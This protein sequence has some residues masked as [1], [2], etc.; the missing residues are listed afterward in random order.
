MSATKRL[1]TKKIDKESIRSGLWKGWILFIGL[2]VIA[3]SA[4][5]IYAL[6]GIQVEN[7]EQFSKEASQKHW[8]RIKE[9][10]ER[11]EILDIN[12]NVLA[13]TSYVYT[14]G[15]TPSDFISLAKDVDEATICSTVA[16][17]LG[18]DPKTLSDAM[19]QVEEPYI[20]LAKNVSK[21]QIDVLKAFL[22]EH[23]IGG[24]A[25]DSVAKRYYPN[26]PL[27]SQI[28]GYATATDGLLA[29]QLGIEAQ[30][31]STLTGKEGYS[32]VEID[33][34]TQ[35]ALP[36]SAPTTINAQNG[37]NVVL[38]IDLTIQDIVETACEDVF[39]MYD[40]I[41]GVTAIVMDPYT[42]RIHAMASYPDF[43]PNAPTAEPEWV[44][45]QVWDSMSEDQQ[46][47]LLISE[48]WRNRAISDT[49]EPGSTFKSLT[50]AIALEEGLTYE[51]EY[52]SDAPIDSGDYTISCWSQKEL[53]NH[54]TETL[55]DAFNNSC[56]PIFV[57]LAQRI[58]I[59]KFYQ[60]IH[61]FGFYMPTGIDLPVE[62]VGIFHKE[63][64][65]IDMQTLSF[66]ESSTV[67]PLQ[68][69][70]AYCAIVNGGTLMTPQIAT[71]LT[72]SNGNV[73]KEFEP[74]AIRTI[75]SEDTSSRI[76]ALMQTVVTE[77]TGREGYVE[78]FS[79]A[80][81]TSTSTI[82]TGENAGLHVLSF[83]SYAPSYDPEIVVLVVVNMPSDK[84]VGSSCATKT[85]ADII[86][87][88]LDY[89]GVERKYSETDYE[90][91][92][93][94]YELP[95]VSGMTYKEARMKLSLEFGK[96]IACKGSEE[97]TDDTIVSFSFPNAGENLHQ[98]STVVLYPSPDA[99]RAEVILPDFTGKNITECIREAQKCG[100]NIVYEGDLT[101]VVV[102]QNPSFIAISPT[103]FPSIT[104]VISPSVTPGVLP[105]GETT[106][107]ET[108]E[109]TL[110]ESSE[111][112][113]PSSDESSE[114]IETET[115]EQQTLTRVEKGMIIHLVMA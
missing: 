66:G 21:S 54:G 41:E 108:S 103:P 13:G 73:V 79:V 59:D 85:A 81:K 78:G 93:T 10:P 91:L 27:A 104:P 7:Y 115:T 65:L 9:E 82:E 111:T 67:T 3:A 24:T 36:F 70:N 84:E 22:R 51:D 2:C 19:K 71:R 34:Y 75:L 37:Y 74:K 92:S 33:N 14:V 15:I 20:Q 94:L 12:G 64:T 4:Y 72:D 38:S 113:D 101:G 109:T 31:N 35:G 26:G 87:K 90:Y 5:L 86:S 61:N 68:L 46:I 83:G 16:A 52:F 44:D 42:G 112:T 18:I 39:D 98:G 58:G 47:K 8:Q 40:V 56:N 60:Y 28:I 76:K 80:G 97:M 48:A 45:K 49:Y 6:Y 62:G 63:P 1:T 110:P 89:M 29:G 100:V 88:T 77:G 53:G 107:G 96:F 25:I 17:T 43:D 102:S 32:Y 23:N 11:G 55:R 30:Y 50:T 95:E 106:S 114:E 105:E 99:P 69:A 57:Q